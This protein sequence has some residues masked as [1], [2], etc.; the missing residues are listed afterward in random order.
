MQVLII[1]DSLFG[2]TEK[3]AVT[4]KESVKAPHRAIMVKVDNFTPHLL[5]GVDLLLVGCPTHGFRPT[6]ATTAMLKKLPKDAL[7][8]IKVAAFDTRISV[9]E[10]KSK[11]FKVMASLFGY[12]AEPVAKTLV[13]RGGIL[14]SE[15]HWFIVGDK[16]GPLREG[17]LEHASTWMAQLLAV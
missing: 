1:Y 16:E 14:A 4:L 10:V 15:T 3:V 11:F 13:Q 6:E 17:E 9:K 5:D 7:V 12:A 8:G 2:N